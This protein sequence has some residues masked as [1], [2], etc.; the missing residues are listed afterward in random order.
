MRN[1]VV[2]EDLANAVDSYGNS[3][4]RNGKYVPPD[5]VEKGWWETINDLIGEPLPTWS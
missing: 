1:K 2:G 5:K 3:Y 4:T